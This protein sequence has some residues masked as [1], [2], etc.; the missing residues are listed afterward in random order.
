MSERELPQEVVD[1]LVGRVTSQLV[2]TTPSEG[3]EMYLEDRRRELAGT[4]IPGYRKS[5]EYFEEHC[6]QNQINN[7]NELTGRDLRDYRTWRREESTEAV[8]A[9]STKTMRDEQYLLRNFIKYLESVDAV[10]PG[11]HEKIVVPTLGPSEGVRDETLSKER[12]TEILDYL[13]RYH[14]ATIEH[15]TWVILCASG[16]RLGGAHSLDVADCYLDTD[17]PYLAFRH[18]P[19]TGTRLK[20]EIEGER[21]ISISPD[22]A[23]LLQ[24]YLDNKRPDVSDDHGRE[25]LLASTHGRIAKS[26]M[27]RYIYKWTRPCQISRN[28]PHD[29]NISE[30]PAVENA[31]VASKCPST[32]SPHSIRRSYITEELDAGIPKD[33]LSDR[34]DVSPEVL[35]KHYDKRTEEQKRRLRKEIMEEVHSNSGGGYLNSNGGTTHE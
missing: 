12:T 3:I 8:D 27:R 32:R 26:M 28:C 30:C 16:G 35:D 31:D 23:E 1:E 29:K 14:Y 4:T 10:P 25:P 13:K 18:R 2:P 21:D 20:N 6:E 34:C 22:I 15:V 11:L 17:D 19:E 7:L 33:L 24:A 9:L 5:L